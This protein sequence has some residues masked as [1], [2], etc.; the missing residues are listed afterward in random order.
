MN[1]QFRKQSGGTLLGLIL[2]LIIG[3]GIAVVVAVTIKNTPLPFIN[4]LGKPDKAV[5]PTAGQVSDPNKPLYGNTSAA[6]EA[7]KEFARR[8]EEEKAMRAEAERESAAQPEQKPGTKPV[9]KVAKVEK[10]D[11]S[12]IKPDMKSDM[13]SDQSKVPVVERSTPEKM[14][15]DKSQKADNTDE[16]FSYYLQAG[17]FREQA[18]AENTRARLALMGVSANVA[19]RQSDN[20]TLYRVR[21]GP[22][23]QLET[24]NRMRG[25]LTDNGVDVAVVRVPK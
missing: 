19:E 8:A 17:A 14:G 7:A 5:G 20:G 18:D 9:E 15:A 22:F 25:K 3:L 24:M 13:K 10:A 6:K 12:D 2:G 21:I 11:K 1:K 4:K 23:A 16:K